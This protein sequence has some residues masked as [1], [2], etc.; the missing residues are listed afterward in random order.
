MIRFECDY[1]EGA[2]PKILEKLNE[3]NFDQQPGYGNDKY[4]KNAANKIKNLC[5]KDVDV[6]FVSSGTQANLI[7]ISSI[8]HPIEGVI[9]AETGHINVHETGA[10]EATGHKV[11]TIPSF[12]G[13]ITG[14]EIEKVMYNHE[15]DGAG[16]IHCVKPGMVFITHPTENGVIYTK[17]ELESIKKI[18]KNYNLPLY[19]DGA[20]LGYGL[21]AENSDLTLDEI[22]NLCDI[23]V[24]GG[25]KIGA[26]IGEAIVICN[27]NLK[28]DFRYY[29]KQ[30]GG[31]LAKG[32]LLGIQFDVLFENDLYFE[33]SKHAINLALKIKNNFVYNGYKML[34]DSTTNQQFP[35]LK[36]EALKTLA[37]KYLFCKW[38]QI[39]E[40]HTAVRF[41]TSWATRKEDV[42][43]LICDI[44]IPI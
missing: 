44:A 38:C 33:I 26:L 31:L 43:E 29:I 16:S 32:R 15:N 22:A 37:K 5:K 42:N 6:H 23:F 39:D 40:N 41:C 28:K 25:T 30:R 2:H 9:C 14:K 20:R 21:V 13:K 17:S 1:N 4:C 36:N 10:I 24:I 8:L 27:N 35:I 7:S 34:Y 3:I 19:I 18:C 11:L 12:D